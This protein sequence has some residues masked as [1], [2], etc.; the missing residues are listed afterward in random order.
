MRYYARRDQAGNI[1][2]VESYSHD[3]KIAGAEEITQEEF[4]SFVDA[5]PPSPAPSPT[6]ADEVTTLKAT[7]ADL[8]YRLSEV[9][10]SRVVP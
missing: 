4:N 10:K 3:L 1:I 9:E 5:L 7:V 2:T 8:E 6:L